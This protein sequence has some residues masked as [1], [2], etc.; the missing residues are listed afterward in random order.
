MRTTFAGCAGASFVAWALAC[1]PT[2]QVSPQAAT[3][4]ANRRMVSPPRVCLAAAPQILPLQ[5]RSLRGQS[6]LGGASGE[7]VGRL[8]SR[9][10]G[11]RGRKEV[12]LAPLRV[13][14]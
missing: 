2:A 1:N 3:I 5:Q 10:P 14:L 7:C 12:A 9:P 8:H 6:L 13:I 4:R 11:G